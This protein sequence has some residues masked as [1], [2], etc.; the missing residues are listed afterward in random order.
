MLI[1]NLKQKFYPLLL[2]FILLF[3]TAIP[4]YAT[5]Y[6][7]TDR[8]K[9]AADDA[10]NSENASKSATQKASSLTEVIKALSVEIAAI[11]AQ[12]AAN[13]AKAYE[14]KTQITIT[15]KKLA[16]QQETLAKLLV[17][18]HF[19]DSDDTL[20]L[21][22]SSSSISDFTEKQSRV[23][24][25]Q[26][27]IVAA[28]KKV[29][30]EKIA[31]EEQKREID[32]TLA[33]QHNLKNAATAKQAESDRLKTTYENNAAAYAKDAEEA[34][35]IKA[36]EIAKETARLNGLGIIG[37]GIN[38]YPY[39][40]ICPNANLAWSDGWGYVCQCVHYTGYK[41][42]ERWGINVRF[43]GNA[44][45]WDDSARAAGYRVDTTPAAGTV[46]VNNS[47][48]WGHVMWVE[49]VNPNG[50]INISEYNNPYSSK[51]HREGDYGYRTI[52][53]AGL[54]FIHFN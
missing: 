21:L 16:S 50:T 20:L 2:S 19:S 34:R 44:Y 39:Q 27:N 10:I 31:L 3:T 12:I 48:A 43:W 1:K 11:S 17:D 6:C 5:D 23:D 54:V 25:I 33:D 45:S 32:R 42:K 9:K 29:K 52:S 47:G 7:V 37:H 35:K 22:A 36:E 14:L 46:A 15:E 49:S 13:D 53:P 4:V 38:S 40:N 18:L 26:E 30:A 28:A 24:A 51:S 8:C 41:V